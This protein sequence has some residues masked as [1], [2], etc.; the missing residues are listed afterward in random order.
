MPKKKGYWFSDTSRAVNLTPPEAEIMRVVWDKGRAV[1][2]REVYE[3]LLRRRRL[4]YTTV[5]SVM[6]KLARKQILIQDRSITTYMYSAA[7]TDEEVAGS[8][9]DGVVDKVLAGAAAPLI[10]RLLGKSRKKLTPEQLKALEELIKK[11]GK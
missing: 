6:S 10:S 7:V 4:A 1:S 9:L 3:I 2:V 5:M 8:I 11:N